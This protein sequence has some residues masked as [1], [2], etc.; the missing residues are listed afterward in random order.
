M[1]KQTTIFLH[2]KHMKELAVLARSQGIK[3]AQL[4]RVILAEHL[5]RARLQA[6]QAK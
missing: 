2:S 4:V 3:T 5:R 1:L 6:K